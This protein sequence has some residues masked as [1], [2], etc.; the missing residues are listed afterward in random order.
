MS[1][2]FSHRKLQ[3]QS[4][5]GQDL[6]GADFTGADIRGTDFSGACLVHANFSQARAGLP[7][8]AVARLLVFAAFLA[9]LS[10]FNAAYAG[11]VFGHLFAS[12]DLGSVVLGLFVA[13]VLLLFCLTTLKNGLGAALGLVSLT[14]ATAIVIIV[15]ITSSVKIAGQTSIS[16]LVLGGAISGVVG[17]ALAISLSRSGKLSLAVALLGIL[18][19]T[20]L[21]ASEEEVL[22]SMVGVVLLSTGI[23]SLATY[24]GRRALKDDPRYR[25][26][27][28]LTINLSTI[29]GT[30]FCNAELTDANF[31]GA[32]LSSTDFR[33]ANLTRTCWQL[34]QLDRTNLERTYLEHPRIRQLLT[35][36]IGNG[37]SQTFDRLDLR[38]VNLK[39]AK[40]TDASLIGTDLSN[41][42]LQGADLS[43][44]KLVQAQLHGA[45]LTGAQ[46]TGAYIQNWGIAPDTIL[47]GIRCD[48]IY[49]RLPTHE[50]PDPCRKPDNRQEIFQEG[51]FTDFIAPII[52][53]L[54][55]Y[56]QQNLD[57]RT[58]TIVPKTLDLY[59][60][61]GIDPSASAIALQQLTEEHPEANISVVS[62]EGRGNQKIRLQAQVSDVVD[63][64]QLNAKYF[65]KYRQISSL[66]YRD[67]QSLLTGAAEKDEH[68]RSLEKL[69]E[70]AISQ[71]KFYVETY[72]NQGEFIMTQSKGN[73]NISGVQGDVSGIAAAG[74]SQTMTGVAIGAI[75]GT[76]TNT[77]NQ[78]PASPDRDNPGIKE[79]LAQLQ[80]A[81]EAESELPDEDKAEALEQVKTLAEAGQKPEDNVLQKA[82]KTSMKILKGTVAS[83]PDATKLVEACTKLLPAIATL[84][85][86]V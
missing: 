52:R 28:H 17:L 86:L 1:Q 71:P 23:L 82:A 67:I 41:A 16:T 39:D 68:I 10:G 54:D 59:H 83:L 48:Y 60:V 62:I 53:T 56:Q 84:L 32:N 70:N 42:D 34:A 12:S 47:N 63:R 21:G 35:A 78:L 37:V 64:S 43:G 40:L 51:D 55:S 57:P 11:A 61:E 73:V 74:E 44:A 66:P 58:L 77:I 20:L 27:H 31:T 30:R 9:L 18:F 85:A 45:N 13:I 65:E 19:G 33:K 75:S 69:L 80:A 24:L 25:L 8:K 6:T 38:G 29:G 22:P 4:F 26:I 5:A 72:Q 49:M 2:D 7:P 81:I 15:G 46:L 79:L 76:V 50:D 36:P 3:Q 14:A